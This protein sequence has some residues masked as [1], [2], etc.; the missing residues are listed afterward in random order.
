MIIMRNWNKMDKTTKIMKKE[1][2]SSTNLTNKTTAMMHKTNFTSFITLQTKNK[3]IRLKYS[4]SH[5]WLLRLFCCW[6]KVEIRFFD[7]QTIQ[8][9]FLPYFIPNKTTLVQKKT[10]FHS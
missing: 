5:S 1:T 3:A 7:L 6:N 10:L 4:P 2:S 8:T 9:L